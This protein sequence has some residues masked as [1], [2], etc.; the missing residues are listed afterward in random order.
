MEP[1][2]NE[3]AGALAG[4]ADEVGWLADPKMPELAGCAE[5]FPNGLDDWPLDWFKKENVVAVLFV[6]GLVGEV[7]GDVLMD[8]SAVPLTG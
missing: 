1:K 7:S 2:L 5:V 6:S 8:S 3:N 4:G